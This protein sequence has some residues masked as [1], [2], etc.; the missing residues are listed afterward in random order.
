MEGPEIQ[1]GFFSGALGLATRLLQ[2]RF[3]R[4]LLAGG[5]NTAFGYGLFYALLLLSGSAMFALTLGTILAVLFNFLT[6]GAF[7]FRTMERHRLWRFFAV[8]G[9]VYIYNAIGLTTLQ[10]FGMAPALAGLVLL[11]GAVV[12]AYLLNRSL[13]F[14][15]RVA[16]LEHAPGGE[17][18]PG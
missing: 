15:P 11:P 8:Y 18:T 14:G 16:S 9:V 17:G 2:I 7:V 1:S 12:L 10:A 5:V 3:L 6:T 13:V 4:F